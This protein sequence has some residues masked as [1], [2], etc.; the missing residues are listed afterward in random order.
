LPN[1]IPNLTNGGPAGD[2]VCRM[3][4]LIRLRLS[5]GQPDHEVIWRGESMPRGSVSSVYIGDGT[6]ERHASRF[7]EA[8]EKQVQSVCRWVWDSNP[9]LLHASCFMLRE[10]GVVLL[11][12]RAHVPG[13]LLAP[14]GVVCRSK[15]GPGWCCRCRI[16]EET[17]KGNK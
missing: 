4:C 17:E 14:C 11:R 2:L 7:V 3:G 15:P 9:F 10:V 16:Q 6:P 8:G 12:G 5:E 1:D 13:D